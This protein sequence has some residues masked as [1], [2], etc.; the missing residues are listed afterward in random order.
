MRIAISIAA[1]GAPDPAGYTAEM[2]G[3]PQLSPKLSVVIP[4]HNE[5]ESIA[6]LLAEVAR[7]TSGLTAEIIVVDDGSSDATAA[8]VEHVGSVLPS[9]RVVRHTRNAGQSAA[10]LSGIRA[11]QAAWIVTMDAD[12]Q[13]DPADIATLIMA[14]D[15]VGEGAPLMV[16]GWRRTRRDSAAKRIA[17]RLANGIRARLLRDATPDTG[18]SLKLF[19][20]A[21]YLALPHFDHNHRFLPAL[22]IRQGGRVIS[23]PVNHRPRLKGQSHYTNWQRLRVGIVDLLGVMWLGRRMRRPE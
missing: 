20:R 2:A 11:A 8:M 9:V 21:L 4:A 5:A 13:N 16:C 18:C 12:G 14:R 1:L 3:E 23:V 10:M 7:A 17:S 6:T 19:P 22:A 15:A